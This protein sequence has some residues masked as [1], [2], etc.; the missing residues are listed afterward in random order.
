MKGIPDFTPSGALRDGATSCP[1]HSTRVPGY[2]RPERATGSQRGG[3]GVKGREGERGKR[4]RA[5]KKKRMKRG[6]QTCPNVRIFVCVTNIYI[7]VCACVWRFIPLSSH[8]VNEKFFEVSVFLLFL[9]HTHIHTP[10]T[11]RWARIAKCQK[12]SDLSILETALN[13]AISSITT[14]CS[15]HSFCGTALT[16]TVQ[17]KISFHFLC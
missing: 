12:N 8:E 16:Q 6:E 9:S 3:C 7:Q 10:E 15:L 13:L 14:T 11:P 5:K 2:P 1:Y 17:S 4:E